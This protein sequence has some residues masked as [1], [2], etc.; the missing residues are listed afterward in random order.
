[1]RTPRPSE[2]TSTRKEGDQPTTEPTPS[3]PGRHTSRHT[4]I[5]RPF[6]D[7]P[8][9][10][11]A[12]AYRPTTSEGQAKETDP[13]NERRATNEERPTEKQNK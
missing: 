5:D 13:F 8:K 9:G 1:M 2:Q 4:I 10:K 7:H 6:T 3:L 11:K 12:A